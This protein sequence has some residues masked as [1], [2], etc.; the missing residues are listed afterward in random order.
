ML[1]LVA[2]VP[3]CA[4]FALGGHV[5]ADTLTTHGDAIVAALRMKD[6]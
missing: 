1:H 2:L 5:L 3:F 4:A 6:R